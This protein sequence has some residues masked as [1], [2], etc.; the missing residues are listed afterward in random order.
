MSLLEERAWTLVFQEHRYAIHKN[1]TVLEL[2][3]IALAALRTGEL[4]RRNRI[5]TVNMYQRARRFIVGAKGIPGIGNLHLAD[6]ETH[7]VHAWLSHVAQESLASARHLRILLLHAFS[8]AERQGL[9][10]W[11]QNPARSAQLPELPPSQPVEISRA[12][13]SALLARI[14]EWEASGKRTDLTGIVCC[15]MATGIR[16]GELPALL[17]EEVNLASTPATMLVSGCAVLQDGRLVRQ[18][19]PKTAAGFRE[20]VLPEWFAAMLRERYDKRDPACPYVFPSKTGTML[21]MSNIGNRFRQARGEEFKHVK[22]KSF[23][24]TVATVIAREKG[25]EEA[26]RHLGHTSPAITGRHY[27]KRARRTGDHNDIL[28]AFRP[29]L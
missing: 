27:I 20:I 24:A 23:R 10:L 3:D 19:E 1:M 17:W 8:L 16:P 22:L 12:E 2:V 28:E 5:Q 7:V 9:S 29:E 13:F 4:G 25:A 14:R 26:A 6:C 18:N 15:L 21:S 11:P